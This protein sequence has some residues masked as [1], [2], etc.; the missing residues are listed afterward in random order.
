MLELRG[1]KGVVQGATNSV[2]HASV[3][4][5]VN[6]VQNGAEHSLIEL[7]EDLFTHDFRLKIFIFKDN[8]RTLK[9]FYNKVIKLLALYI[10]SLFSTVVNMKH[11]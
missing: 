7:M 3:Q 4:N 6:V 10:L 1:V 5:V 2:V 8:D 11:V 9:N